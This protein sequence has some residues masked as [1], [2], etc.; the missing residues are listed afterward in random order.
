MD[1]GWIHDHDLDYCEQLLYDSNETNG[2]QK[3]C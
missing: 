3:K 2:R 1:Y